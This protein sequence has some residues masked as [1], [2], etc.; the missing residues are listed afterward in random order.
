MRK[1]KKEKAIKF[2][3]SELV[4]GEWYIV[5]VGNQT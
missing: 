2:Q 5:V 4:V 3:L 1:M